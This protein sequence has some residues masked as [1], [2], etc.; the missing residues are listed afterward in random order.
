MSP[1]GRPKGEFLSAKRE[2]R[3]MVRPG[4][5]AGEHLSAGRARPVR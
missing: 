4:R 1:Q 3:P 2:G 5:L